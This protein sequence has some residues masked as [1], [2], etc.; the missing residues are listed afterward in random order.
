MATIDELADRLEW[1]ESELKRFENANKQNA[2]HI[3]ELNNLLA[4][5]KGHAQFARQRKAEDAYEALSDVVIS[6]MPR[7]SALLS[8]LIIRPQR[9]DLPT[10]ANTVS[11]TPG[12]R[13]VL[14]VDDEELI[15]TF[16][17]DVL[18]KAGYNVR[19]A[20]TG[21][22]A[23]VHC[24]SQHFDLIMMDFWLEDMDG[25]QAMRNIRELCPDARVIF[26]T[27]DP[28]IE[29]IH[30][31]VRK[32]GADG[33]ITKPFELSDILEAVERILRVSSAVI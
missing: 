25:V 31:I 12:E 3:N 22:E 33:F 10:L 27:G 20:A 26:M 14:L 24:E 29:E 28:S 15:R 4:A 1:L 17:H 9:E 8:E 13:F 6:S 11:G 16:L 7:I 21:R 30:A 19:H 2:A 5:I 23:V 32:E 18:M